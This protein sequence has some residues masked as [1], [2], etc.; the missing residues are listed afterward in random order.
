LGVELIFTTTNE[1]LKTVVVSCPHCGTKYDFDIK[2][3]G[4]SRGA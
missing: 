3:N 1:E 2:T 4:P